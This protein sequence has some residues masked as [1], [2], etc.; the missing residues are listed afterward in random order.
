MNGWL[1][2]AEDLGDLESL[3]APYRMATVRDYIS[4][5]G[6]FQRDASKIINLGRSYDYQSAGYYASLLAEARGHRVIPS[7]E[8]I[9]DLSAREGHSRAIP[10]LEDQLNRELAKAGGERPD[11]VMV[12]FGKSDNPACAGF[13]RLLFDWFRAPAIL[14][15]LS[16]DAASGW[17]RITRLALRP[18]ARLTAPE[19][20]FFA[21]ALEAH[22]RRA[23][24]SSKQRAP[25]RYSIGVLFD[26]DEK[27]PP[28]GQATLKHWARQA[29]KV[30]VE[31][32]PIRRRDLPRL[33]EFDALF[34]RETTSIRN[35]TYRFAQRARA[36]GMPVI[37]DT[38]SMIR[39]TNKVYLWE[40]LT[41]AGLPTPETLVLRPNANLAEVGD[42]LGFPV[43]VKIPDGSFGRGVRKA[44][45]LA[46]LKA[47]T[48]AFA[49]ESDLLLAQKFIPTS[50]DWRIGVLDNQPLFACQY[51]MAKGHWQIVQHRTDGRAVEGGFL[52]VALDAAPPEVVDIAVRA[53]G[54]IGDGLYGVDIKETPDGPVVIEI[55]D[56]PNLDHGVEDARDGAEIWPRL[57][58]WFTDRI[59]R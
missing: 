7:V 31:V 58:R 22:T 12:C 1:L 41:Q 47:L 38:V 11:R 44:A 56:N 43:V 8:T 49:K 42:R 40:R 46:E 13:G 34:I 18:H 5:P 26:P 21:S 59:G 30:G 53:A 9:L 50:Y 51:Q 6:V 32:E 25:L 2:L 10:E 19:K 48:A 20:A 3:G 55:N 4:R 35:H 37:D 23:W 57:T 24:R 39:C 15:T 29:E 45:D 27:L 54:L 36:E 16:T 52:T 14:C 17:T 33:A 28:S